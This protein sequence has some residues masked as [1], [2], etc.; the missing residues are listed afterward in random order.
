[1]ANYTTTLWVRV[2]STKEVVLESGVQT[3]TRI[4]THALLADKLVFNN[5]PQLAFVSVHVTDPRVLHLYVYACFV[6]NVWSWKS[7]VWTRY[8]KHCNGRMHAIWVNAPQ[9]C[10]WQSQK[11]KENENGKKNQAL[12]GDWVSQAHTKEVVQES[13]LQRGDDWELCAS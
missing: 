9:W 5:F 8:W 11:R 10:A 6:Y 3:R 2:K 13:G 4:V 1:M 7:L 12:K